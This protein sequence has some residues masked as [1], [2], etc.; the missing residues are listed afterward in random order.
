MFH[1]NETNNAIGKAI[2][3]SSASTSSKRTFATNQQEIPKEKCIYCPNDVLLSQEQTISSDQV[4]KVL[5]NVIKNTGIRYEVLSRY[6]CAKTFFPFCGHCGPFM[7]RMWKPTQVLEEEKLKLEDIYEEFWVSVYNGKTSKT[8]AINPSSSF[9]ALAEEQEPSALGDLQLEGSE[10]KVLGKP[11]HQNAHD[12]DDEDDDDEDDD[13]DDG[14]II[15]NPEQQ[16]PS[17]ES[18]ETEDDGSSVDPG[19]VAHNNDPALSRLMWNEDAETGALSRIQIKQERNTATSEELGEDDVYSEDGNMNM[20][21]EADNLHADNQ[22]PSGNRII[23]LR[24]QE[25]DPSQYSFLC[26]HCGWLF[27]TNCNLMRHMTIHTPQ[28]PSPSPSTARRSSPRL[29]QSG[30]TEAAGAGLNVPVGRQTRAQLAAGT[31]VV[32]HRRS[33]RLSTIT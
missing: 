17:P 13:D 28:P 4:E 33:A 27:A 1:K 32:E 31:T 19:M 6:R 24:G 21:M 5:N 8:S 12:D 9:V 11:Q 15:N 23:M 16:R 30:G 29:R 22:E 25:R 2:P 14:D 10:N 20:E 7:V 18:M 3:G 26:H